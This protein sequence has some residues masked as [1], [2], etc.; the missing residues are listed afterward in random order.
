MVT[1][2]T[3]KKEKG[4]IIN[5]RIE[6]STSSCIIQDEVMKVTEDENSTDGQKKEYSYTQEEDPLNISNPDEVMKEN[7]HKVQEEG[8]RRLKD[9]STNL[10][11]DNTWGP[12]W[13]RQYA[14]QESTRGRGAQ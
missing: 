8:S 6:N 9:E 12:C 4:S 3:E 14:R 5:T 11:Q 7:E 10:K 1:R 2:K 13:L